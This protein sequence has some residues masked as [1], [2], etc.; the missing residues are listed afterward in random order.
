VITPFFQW[1]HNGVPAGNNWNRSVNN[2]QTGLDYFNRT[3]TAKSN[4]FD[5]RPTAT[6]YFY[7]DFDSTG[8]VLDGGKQYEVTFAAGQLPPVKGFWSLTLYNKHHLF[9][10]NDLNRYSV[11]TKNKDL[12]RGSDGSLTIYVGPT[13]P[14]KEKEAN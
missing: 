9:S 3:G 1:K 12:V 5:N 7:T 6:Q 10:A 4:M 13:S 8:A 2:A 14:G 11:G